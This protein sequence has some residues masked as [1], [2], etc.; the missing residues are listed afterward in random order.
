[1]PE[2][3]GCS[4][5][6]S[7]MLNAKRRESKDWARRSWDLYK[8]ITVHIITSVQL[9]QVKHN[10]M[11][12]L[13]LA[14]YDQIPSEKY[15]HCGMCRTRVAFI[16]DDIAVDVSTSL[17]RGIY[18]KVFNVEVPADDLSYHQQE[19]GNTLVDTYCVKCGMLLGHKLYY[20]DELLYNDQVGGANE[21]GP[22]D[23]DAGANEQNA[24]QDGGANEQDPNDQDVV[25]MS[26]I[27]I[28]MG[29]LMNRFLMSKM[30]I[31]LEMLMN[32]IMIKMEA[33]Q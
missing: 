28:N 6:R 15:I 12:R 26:K 8:S 17:T 1:M 3:D 7:E 9:K 4:S 18:S 22:K 20:W 14:E 25:L 5:E 33:R 2:V 29:A 11:G 24:D 13:F 32:R 10:T 21:Q 19:N 16:E 31:K 23:Q 27:L 30:L